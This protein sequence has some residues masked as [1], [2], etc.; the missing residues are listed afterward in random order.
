MRSARPA[1]TV[2]QGTSASGWRPWR[3]AAG[4]CASVR[5]VLARFWAA[6]RAGEML[7]QKSPNLWPEHSES[8]GKP[9]SFQVPGKGGK[10]TCPGSYSIAGGV[11]FWF[12][13]F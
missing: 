7:L 10:G 9:W 4:M 1:F 2:S 8:S 6:L 13:C 12:L 11:V 5:G 3:K